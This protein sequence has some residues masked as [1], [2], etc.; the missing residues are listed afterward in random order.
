MFTNLFLAHP[1]K[2]RVSLCHGAASV[3]RP[4]VRPPVRPSTFP[5]KLLLKNGCRDLLLT[6]HNCSL[7]SP[8]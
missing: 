4:P 1:S 7:W 3:V 2:S 8:D 6:W 5:F